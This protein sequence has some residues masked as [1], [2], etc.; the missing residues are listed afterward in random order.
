MSE[1][2]MAKLGI[3]P[4]AEKVCFNTVAAKRR[5][6]EKRIA[7]AEAAEHKAKMALDAAQEALAQERE[8]EKAIVREFAALMREDGI[9]IGEEK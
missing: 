8:A 9:R 6:Q 2:V 1:G 3:V 5:A 4:K 7:V